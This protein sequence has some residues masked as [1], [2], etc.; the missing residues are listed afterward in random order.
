MIVSTVLRATLTSLPGN[1]PP[2]DRRFSTA[3]SRPKRIAAAKIMAAT[4]RNNV[5]TALPLLGMPCQKKFQMEL[6][7]AS[8]SLVQTD[9]R[10]QMAK[11]RATVRRPLLILSSNVSWVV[12]RVRARRSDE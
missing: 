12:P 7:W 9:Q 5:G 10:M 6:H 1:R 3:D 11:K 2:R 4:A 8:D